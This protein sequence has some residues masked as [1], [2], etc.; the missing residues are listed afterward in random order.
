MMYRFVLQKS[1][2]VTGVRY[3]SHISHVSS[4][5]VWISYGNNLILTNTAGDK[6]HHLTGIGSGYGVHTVTGDGDL[7]Y[8]DSEFN[9]NKLSIDNKVKCTLIKYNT[10]PWEPVCVYSSPSSGDLLVGMRNTNTDTSKLVWYKGKLVRYNSTGQHIQTIQH[11]RHTGE[12]LYRW[13]IYITESSN[14]DVIVSDFHSDAVVVT[15]WGGRHRFYTGRPSGSRLLP[16][17]IC[18]DV[19]SHILV[20]DFKTQTVQMIESNGNFLSQLK[21]PPHGIDSPWGLSYDDRTC[22]LWVGSDDDTVN[23]YRVVGGHSL[24]GFPFECI[25][26]KKH[27]RSPLEQFCTPCGV[28][29][30][31]ECTSSEDHSRHELKYIEDLFHNI[32]RIEG[33][34]AFLMCLLLSNSYKINMREGKWINKYNAVAESFQS[35][36]ITK[37]FTLEDL[38]KY[39]PVLKFNESEVRFSS[40]VFK[41]ISFLKFS[42][43]SKFVDIFLTQAEKGNI[44]E[45]CRSWIYPPKENEVFCWLLPKQT[46]QL[47][48]RLGEDIF[49]HPTMEDPT[50]HDLAFSK[51]GIPMQ[52]ILRGDKSVMNFIQNLKKGKTTMYHAS[53]MIIGCAG[54]GKTTLLERL[55]GIDL[56][57]IKE[58]I[59]STRGVDIH[60]DVFDVTDS[61]QVNSSSQQQRFKISFEETNQQLSDPENP[62]EEAI[63]V[64]MLDI[65]EPLDSGGSTA[66]ASYRGQ[67]SHDETNI[68]S[69]S[70]YKQIF[71][72]SNGREAIEGNQDFPSSSELSG[73]LQIVTKD[74]SDDPDKKVTMTDF[75]GQCAYY[76][77][78]QIFLSP[79]AFFI[80]VL[81]M[82]KE[83]DDKVGEEVC[84]QESSIYKGWTHRDYLEFWMK[85][86]HQYSSDKAPVIL[87][88]TH[89]ENKTEKEK[90]LFFRQIWKILEMREK[91]LHK[92]LDVKRQFAIGFHD[93]E[94]IKKIKLSILD[95]V[96]KLDHW[97]EEL[98]QSWAMF[99]KF[100]QEKKNVKILNKAELQRF[101][102]A[103][104]EGIKLQTVEDINVMLQFFHDSREILHFDQEFLNVVIILDVQ[105]FADAF[106]NVITDENHAK[107]DLF[108]LASEWDK[109]NEAGELQDTLLSAIWRMNNNG[110][111][112][113]KDDIMLYM[114]KL[115]LLAKL[116]DKKWY[117]PCM[118][119]IPFRMEYFSSYTASSIICYSFDLLPA[120]LFHRL[121]ATCIQ[122]PWEIFS[123]GDQKCIYQTAAVFMYQ[124]MHHN[125][126]LGM[127]QTEIQL[128]VFVVEG[129]VD[130]SICHQIRENIEGMLH[131]LSNTFEEN[132]KFHV[133]FKC[134]PT[135]FCDS[136][137]STVISE[138]KFIRDTFLC[139][140]C[141][142]N[143]K[144]PVNTNNITKYWIQ[145]KTSAASA[146]VTS[147]QDLGGRS[148][149][150]KLG[151]A[152]NDV[153]IQ[154]CRDMLEFEVP[155]SHIENKVKSSQIK[156]NKDQKDLVQKAKSS[157]YKSFDISLT[158]TLIRNICST[159]PKPTKGTWGGNSMP[160]AGETTVGDDIERIRLIRN[161]LTA[162][163]SSASTPQTE[164]DDTWSMMS[165]IC[166]RLET[167]TG[168]KYLDNLNYIQKLT[169]KEEDEDAIIEKVKIESQHE[170]VKA[171]MSDVQE[172][173]SD[174]KDI[175]AAVGR[176]ESQH[177][178]N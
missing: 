5:R 60:T 91:T 21:T 95:V 82:E 104:P 92:H 134:K 86:I 63:D 11:D 67:M 72:T 12:E 87:V 2:T 93:N 89:S 173:W 171:I 30:C 61:I 166:K 115:G 117:V 51:F 111:I 49:K 141:P 149:F 6:L 79:R 43:N 8:I 122:I 160:A 164:F 65:V 70:S 16:R 165:D 42:R 103:L 168:K 17:G 96:R 167:F 10:A 136:K 174:M 25:K 24:T 64:E 35:K 145:I 46:E 101:N 75:A 131:K 76:A 29:L 34:N 135:G 78:H 140:S 133:A 41:D 22:L 84:R 18:T 112:D 47:I 130:V 80:L 36:E 161:N 85:S 121:I 32:H 71:A 58:N 31:V 13:P 107:E 98:P 38:E 74:L 81:N 37:P 147:G 50:V 157:G 114:E 118:N 177:A 126:L 106:K 146:T 110:Y 138:C 175:K 3:C 156:I 153:L 170:M 159:I 27:P 9:I 33:G 162:H 20:C 40:D 155:P 163:V 109:F 1:V 28:P 44:A 128:Q 125:I 56:E 94:S 144:H 90:M 176:L 132:S 52:V 169:L 7:I 15:D 116:S 151:M 119:K 4:D 77:S 53:G 66:E 143:K 150:A 26:C 55:K 129:E 158:Y 108:H 69:T 154:A 68:Q 73:I 45:Y 39:K 62:V 178:S 23:I 152:T 14:G 127:T 57:E 172:M 99:E 139:P 148:R 19:L 48:E 142:A 102:D 88:G 105:W 83:F 54:S 137:E 113:H 124:D 100:F 120:G 97:G 123:D 59:S